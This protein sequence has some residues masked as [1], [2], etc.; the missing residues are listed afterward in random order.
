M[1]RVACFLHSW[2]V[3]RTLNQQFKFVFLALALP[4]ASVCSFLWFFHWRLQ[5][6]CLNLQH[7]SGLPPVE[8]LTQGLQWV[9][10]VTYFLHVSSRKNQ[11]PGFSLLVFLARKPLKT[12]RAGAEQHTH[13]GID[14]RVS[15][16]GPKFR[17]RSEHAPVLQPAGSGRGLRAGGRASQG[18]AKSRIPSPIFGDRAGLW[19]DCRRW[20]NKLDRKRGELSRFPEVLRFGAG[21][22]V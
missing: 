4:R 15:E 12:R 3:N 14:R 1:K 10:L 22:S 16:V 21:A 2:S 19:R 5:S 11:A 8:A 9:S 7:A 6:Q 17:W 18:P 13:V 20:C